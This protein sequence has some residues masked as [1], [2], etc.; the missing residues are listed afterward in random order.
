MAL[1]R[2]IHIYSLDTGC[3]YTR[4]EQAIHKKMTDALRLKKK[5]KSESAKPTYLKIKEK[6]KKDIEEMKGGDGLGFKNMTTREQVVFLRKLRRLRRAFHKSRNFSKQIPDILKGNPDLQIDNINKTIREYKELLLRTLSRKSGICRQ[7]KDNR[8]TDW[9]KISIF[10]STLTRLGDMKTNELTK[11]II[12]VQTFFYDVIEQLVKNGFM[13]NGEKY[14]Y[15]TSSAGQIRT[16][17]TVFIRESV[18]KVLQPSLMC[19]LT[20]DKINKVGGVN[21][22]KYL[23]YLALCNSATDL[24]ETFDIKKCI[25]VPDFETNVNTEVDFINYKTYKINRQTMD[26]PIP[27]TDGCGMILPSVS[28]KNFMVRLPWV[29]GLLAVFDFKKFIE[30]HDDCSPIVK[31]I[32]DKEWNVLEDNIE[33]IFTKSQFKM[34][35]Y[36]KS[37]EQYQDWFEKYNCQ[38]GVC[39]IEEDFIPRATINYQ[40]LQSLTDVT[41]E[42][43]N[44]LVK[45]S[46]NTLKQLTSDMDTMYRVFGVTKTNRNKTPFQQCLELYPALLKD[47]H[48]KAV[49]RGIKNSLVKNF[50]AGKLEIEGKYTFLIPDLYAFCE[51]LFCGDDNPQ[52]LLKNQEVFCKLYRQY[53]KLDCLRSP[54]LFREHA[55][56][57]NVIEKHIEKWF[58]TN[59]IYTSVHDPISKILQFDDL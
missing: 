28:K 58:T 39:N 8:L 32:Y 22:N 33:V 16:K 15:F 38:A 26:V 21:V 42:E 36:Y 40:M 17:K 5:C 51:K 50:R 54:H 49:L 44:H 35:N 45:G 53:K 12:V 1:N 52:G 27:H 34:Y 31:D 18:W 24:W 20:I 47:E 10:E 30:E 13:Y 23:A 37:W 4:R 9:R 43:F 57:K 25:V 3:F 7:L 11:D 56:R 29:K 41:K 2:Q 19:G 46:N 6:I 14:R 48:T 59:A 55:V